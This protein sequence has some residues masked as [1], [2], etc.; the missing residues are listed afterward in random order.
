[1]ERAFADCIAVSGDDGSEILGM[2]RADVTHVDSNGGG[3]DGEGC[4]DH[5]D[6]RRTEGLQ[7]ASSIRFVQE[8]ETRFTGTQC[9]CCF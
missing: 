4:I 6:G 2:A 5:R 3:N 8:M 9:C 7:I 1:M